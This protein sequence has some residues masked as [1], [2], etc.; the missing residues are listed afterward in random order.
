MSV[1]NTN[2][3]EVV[4]QKR[5][6]FK[7][8][9][10]EYTV[11]KWDTLGWIAFK[12]WFEN[13]WELIEFN[14]ALW[15]EIWKNKHRIY[16]W[17][18]I[19]LPKD[20]E[21]YKREKNEILNLLKQKKLN[22][23]VTSWDLSNLKGELNERIFPKKPVSIWLRRYLEWFW[24]YQERVFD[25]EHA[26]SVLQSM[27]RSAS[28]SHFVKMVLS[29]SENLKELPAKYRK[30]LLK[31]NIDAWNF[32]IEIKK[33]WSSQVMDLMEFFEEWR[34]QSRFPI[35]KENEPLYENQILELWEYLKN[36]WKVW[37]LVPIYFRWSHYLDN[38]FE[39]NK[40]R[41]DKHFNT[42]MAI[43][44]W[45]RSMN[46]EASE[47]I[48]NETD[49]I[50][51]LLSFLEK[52]WDLSNLKWEEWKEIFFKWLEKYHNII[53]VKVNWEEI[54]II[55][56]IGKDKNQRIK[57]KKTD[58]I[59]ISWPMLMDWLHMQNSNDPD[60]VKNMN[61]RTRFLWEFVM[62]WD[63]LPTELIEH[64][65]NWPFWE[66]N[67][68]D[69]RDKIKI[70]WVYSLKKWEYKLEKKIKE[71]ILEIYKDEFKSLD[72]NSE[73]YKKKLQYYYARQIKWLQIMW[74]LEDENN[75]NPLATNINRWIPFFD[76]KNIDELFREYIANKRKERL[77]EERKLA[78]LKSYV[79]IQTFP[80]DDY[81]MIFWRVVEYLKP[82]E[83][84]IKFKNLWK[85]DSFNE[86]LKRKFLKE[87]VDAS[88]KLPNRKSWV[89]IEDITWK[90]I[91]N[92]KI[93]PWVKFILELDKLDKLIWE[94]SQ[95]SYWND[96][97]SKTRKVDNE[98][99]NAITETEME[100]YALRKIIITETYVFENDTWW[101]PNGTRIIAKMLAERNEW[102]RR[103]VRDISSYWD[104]QLRI[105][106]LKNWYNSEWPTKEDLQ[107]AIWELEKPE[108]KKIIQ[109]VRKLDSDNSEHID[110]DLRKIDEI[111]GII[112]NIDNL[113]K[114]IKI[115]NSYAGNIEAVIKRNFERLVELL[116]EIIQI[117]D[118]DNSRVVW[119]IISWVLAKS[120]IKSHL[121]NLS[122]V[123][124]R[125]WENLDDF[126]SD[127][128][129]VE[130]LQ[131]IAILS[132]NRWEAKT[133][134]WNN[135]NYIL[136]IIKWIWLESNTL[137]NL[138]IPDLEIEDYW[139]LKYSKDIYVSQIKTNIFLYL[140]SVKWNSKLD[141]NQK[142]IIEILEKFCNEINENDSL[143]NILEKIYKLHSNQRL[144][145]ILRSK[146]IST[147][148][149]PSKEEL[150]SN[151]FS[152]KFY[153]HITKIDKKKLDD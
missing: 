75:L 87:F 103:H 32:P 36:K 128:K 102:L 150:S 141:D 122:W 33:I 34:I 58:K 92:W 90:N 40:I 26:R 37:S 11:E 73:E 20:I 104:F 146:N 83:W 135:T 80:L 51:F 88:L 53:K 140:N 124:Q 43:F 23:A 44:I 81:W 9:T 6:E 70:L 101:K 35:T 77:E 116:L 67:F 46:F 126:Y 105:K 117:D 94:I 113:E 153:D 54:N 19:F 15:N 69:Y 144:R 41:N 27:E 89:K 18:I 64:D 10:K 100:E 30:F 14:E 63:F 31:E 107:N 68:W 45:N 60:K 66:R 98:V 38:V 120:K 61:A 145:E 8:N 137:L 1:E 22:D 2:I 62:T 134:L 106:D 138:N 72:K 97:T 3:D 79:D 13:Y 147:S 132:Y 139:K 118:D 93:T 110:E 109:K 24:N 78:K 114:T 99:I 115:G 123:L 136:R 119:K 28:C 48:K 133:T 47:V 129:N 16:I 143:W 84:T 148:I 52:R 85:L 151:S 152:S 4:S 91:L 7:E 42:H 149:L 127:P 65:E 108:V 21:K 112:I 25:P 49:S 130:M 82:Y 96:Y 95:I 29:Q 17:D 76:T 59:E 12:N 142:E 39:S 121:K 55:S 125:S 57:I 50:D 86:V 74:Y 5:K 131:D 111:K 71:M 56:E